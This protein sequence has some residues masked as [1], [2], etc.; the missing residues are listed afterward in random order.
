MFKISDVLITAVNNS[1]MIDISIVLAML[2]WYSFP[3][4]LIVFSGEVDGLVTKIT[5][6][7]IF[8]QPMQKKLRSA[9]H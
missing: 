8:D 6:F 1:R 7:W 3:F 9:F 5:R 2:S 4:I